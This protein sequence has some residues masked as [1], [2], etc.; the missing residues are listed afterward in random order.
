M[1]PQPARLHGLADCCRRAARSPCKCHHMAGCIA[2]VGEGST[3]LIAERFQSI[4]VI[5]G[6]LL[7][8]LLESEADVIMISA[9]CL[10]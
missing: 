2:H 7:V 10:A 4:L 3:S 6:L 9:G 8:E 5:K 1:V